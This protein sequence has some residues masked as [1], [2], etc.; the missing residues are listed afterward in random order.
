VAR[1][2]AAVAGIGVLLLM[3]ASAAAG[4][5]L[6]IPG[7]F[8]DSFPSPSPIATY[9]KGSATIAI[10]DGETVKLDRVADGSGLDAFFGSNVRWTNDAGWNLRVGGAG[11][12]EALGNTSYLTLDLIADGKHLTTYDPSRCIVDVEVA[13]KTGLRGHATCKGVEWYDALDV[14]IPR[15]SE[16]ADEPKFDA[17]LTFEAT[18]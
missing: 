7:G 9:F 14:Q 17:E 11:S 15:P 13:D 10:K 6:L 5:E 2:G 18:P 1:R 8:N 3:I 16:E 4:C 12:Q